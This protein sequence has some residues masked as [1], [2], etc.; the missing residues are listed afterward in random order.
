MAK[1]PEDKPIPTVDNILSPDIFADGV[2]GVFL[3]NGNV[4]I[5]FFSRRCDYSKVPNEFSNVV[6]GR[7]VMPFSGADNMVNFLA[8]FVERMKK[9]AE[10]P[11][12]NP[13]PTIQ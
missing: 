2:A 7:L 11:P 13:P 10:N 8:E 3:N 1:I 6:I 5:T 9:Q 4:H 12:L